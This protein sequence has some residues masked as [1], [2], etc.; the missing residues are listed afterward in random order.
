MPINFHT[1]VNRFEYAKRQID[2]RWIEKILEIV[3]PQG[4]HVIEIG[5]G[6][7]DI[8]KSLGTA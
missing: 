5:C 1:K 7:G 3:N 2:S 4:K 8:Y 6:G